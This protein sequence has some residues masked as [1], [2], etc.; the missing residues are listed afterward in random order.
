M[1][2]EDV[3]YYSVMNRNTIGRSVVMQMD[4]ASV[5]YTQSSQFK[6]CVFMYIYMKSRKMVQTNLFARQKQDRHRQQRCGHSAKER[7]GQIGRTGLT[8]IHHQV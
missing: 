2:N 6:Y 3:V 7:V 4:L 5:I 8:C 1:D